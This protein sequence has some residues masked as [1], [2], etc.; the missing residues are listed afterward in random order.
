MMLASLMNS[1][2][3]PLICVFDRT[4]SSKLRPVAWANAAKSLSWFVS[5][6]FATF[7]TSLKVLAV[8]P[9]GGGGRPRRQP[10]PGA[11]QRSDGTS[12]ETAARPESI[13]A[14]PRSLE[15]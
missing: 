1:C 8:R 14:G 6:R 5:D 10:G 7:F 4:K 13:L 3:G 2:S 12:L 15:R 11:K 9:S